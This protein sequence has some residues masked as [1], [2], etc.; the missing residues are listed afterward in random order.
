M[1]AMTV[2]TTPQ[3]V[4]R[5]DE[6]ALL[7]RAL[8]DRGVAVLVGA[9]GVGKT[10]LCRALCEAAPDSIW[11]AATAATARVRLWPLAS[12]LGSGARG[13]GDPGS[14]AYAVLDALRARAADGGLLV[15]VDDAHLLDPAS[16]AVIHELA[17]A[18]DAQVLMALAEGERAPSA[19]GALWKDLAPR[20]D[21]Q[22]LS[23]ADTTAVVEGLLGAAA[24]PAL[25]RWAFALSDGNPLYIRELVAGA[26]AQGALVQ[27][28]GSWRLEGAPAPSR[29][30]R[31]L[32]EARL[33][34]L[35]PAGRE[36]LE[37]VALG[38]PLE[39]QWLERHVGSAAVAEAERRGGVTCTDDGARVTARC[40]HP[41]LGEV[42]RATMPRA[43]ARAARQAIAD[44]LEA[45]GT[46]RRG[47]LLRLAT[48]RLEGGAHDPSL[49]A[50]A[51]AAALAD[52]DPRFAIRLGEAADDGL[53][54]ALIVAAGRMA[55]GEHERAEEALAPHEAQAAADPVA[56][57]YVRLRA[58][59][60]QWGGDADAAL[61]LVERAS[62]W[63]DCPDWDALL[64]SLRAW[65]LIEDGRLAHAAATGRPLLD[66]A[67]VTAPVLLDVALPVGLALLRSGRTAEVEDLR[68]SVA[69]MCDRA[70]ERSFEVEWI[71]FWF[72]T[73]PALESGRD[74]ERAERCGVELLA[75]S[76]EH[77][78]D[79]LAAGAGAIP[80]H[81]SS[82]SGLAR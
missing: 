38:E 10:R 31:D 46:R 3:L 82:R 15:C 67:D 21:L 49:F 55:T 41:L 40:G 64:A 57:E 69:A 45:A 62:A 79:A 80:Q 52:G 68:P 26:L 56:V 2:A 34:G 6:L 23:R 42:A 17:V 11:V 77:G 7:R 19:I 5:D 35:S 48:L 63:R 81:G 33:T 50:R 24:E 72:E 30:L 51:G 25:A 18:S 78:V 61:A 47:D 43:A 14:T 9:P 66:R 39:L 76:E 28:E 36:A 1:R 32:V 59:A 13:A 58:R 70:G 53:R 65:T 27:A 75:R 54:A 71:R 20:V 4:G 44:G 74:L 29:R 8:D 73:A 22:P 12:V 16:A 60:L 37:L